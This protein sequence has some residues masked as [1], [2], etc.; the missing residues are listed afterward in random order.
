VVF[1]RLDGRTSAIF[2]NPEAA[3]V[4]LAEAEPL[5]VCMSLFDRILDGKVEPRKRVR[6][7]VECG[8]PVEEHKDWCAILRGQEELAQR[9]ITVPS[10]SKT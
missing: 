4:V 1:T 10:A 9:G 2:R 5:E 7:C 6:I 3:S 8:M